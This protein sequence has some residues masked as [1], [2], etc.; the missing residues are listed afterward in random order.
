MT[1]KADWD[2]VLVDAGQNVQNIPVGDPTKW[3]SQIS[4]D[5]P[6]SLVSVF[7]QQIVMARTRDAYSRSWALVGQLTLPQATWNAPGVFPAGPFPLVV[8]LEIVMGVG[9][10][11]VLQDVILMCGNNPT[12]G[13]CNTQNAI[14]GG[15]YLSSFGGPPN[16]D[17]SRPFSAIGAL[18]GNNINVRARYIGGTNVGLPTASIISAIITPFAAGVGL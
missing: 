4:T 6:A 8:A 13:I 9:Q 5:L 3:G 1:G 17:E 18:V 15:P 10:T 16:F 2:R 14:N 12:V 11:Q 7:S